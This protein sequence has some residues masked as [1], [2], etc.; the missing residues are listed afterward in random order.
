MTVASQPI[1]EQPRAAVSQSTRKLALYGSF[2]TVLGYGAGNLIRLGSNLILTRLL[3]PAVF[4]EMAII[5]ILVQG[6]QMFSDIGVGPS[7]IRAKEDDERF[8][9]TAWTLSVIRGWA[10][11]G[12]CLALA[13]PLEKF[14]PYP[15]LRYLLVVAG[16]QGVMDGCQSM[17]MFTQNKK[18]AIKSLTLLALATQ[19]SGL[20]VMI[21]L[22]YYFHSIWALVI[23]GL[24]GASITML[25]SHFALPGIRHRFAWDK[26]AVHEL[27][28]FGKWIFVSTILTFGSSQADRMMLGKMISQTTLGIYS[29][30]LTLATLPNTAVTHLSYAILYPVFAKKAGERRDRFAHNVLR[31]RR[32]LLPLGATVVAGLATVAQPFYHWLYRPAYWDAAWMAQLLSVYIWFWMLQVSADRALIALGDTRSVMFS[33]FLNLV[34]TIVGCLVGFHYWNMTGFIIGLS[35]SSLCGHMVIEIALYKHGINIFRQ[36]L[37]ATFVAG[38]VTAAALL[39]GHTAGTFVH[40]KWHQQVIWIVPNLVLGLLF[41]PVALYVIRELRHQKRD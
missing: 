31:A 34:V 13:W 25:G 30:A 15:Q 14:Y 3:A 26:A 12:L 24:F 19:V 1:V 17:S 5:L 29:Q 4:G 27:F 41:A 7:V 23:G 32:M 21:A 9:N 33:N 22:A 2:W 38:T 11:W 6:L 40:G 8:L 28:H 36:D 18:L 16:F 37:V 10:L 35:F 20:A 39:I